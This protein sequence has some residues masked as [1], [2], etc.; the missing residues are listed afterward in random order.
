MIATHYGNVDSSC[1]RLRIRGLVCT[2]SDV[3]NAA[4]LQRYF[5]YQPEPVTMTDVPHEAL[6]IATILGVDEQ[7]IKNIRKILTK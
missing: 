5:D 4:N 3:V 2:E 6:R 7:I 1:Q